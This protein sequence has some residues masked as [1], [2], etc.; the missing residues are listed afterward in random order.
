MTARIKSVIEREIERRQ[1]D[2]RVQLSKIANLQKE[3]E[4]QQKEL[5]KF[6]R[7]VA[8]SRWALQDLADAEQ[9]AKEAEQATT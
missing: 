3:L 5:A 1:G 9:A 4:V 7:A 2:L 6:E 8:E